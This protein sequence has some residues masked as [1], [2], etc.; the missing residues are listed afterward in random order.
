ML[1]FINETRNEIR[2]TDKRLGDKEGGCKEMCVK[3]GNFTTFSIVGGSCGS[4]KKYVA[5]LNN[6]TNLKSDVY[7]VP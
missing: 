4:E 2:E 3:R 7:Q 1:G 6:G 5:P